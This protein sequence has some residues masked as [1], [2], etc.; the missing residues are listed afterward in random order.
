MKY[1]NQRAGLLLR[2][3]VA[4]IAASF[5]LYSGYQL[6]TYFRENDASR[7][8]TE[9]LVDKAVTVTVTEPAQTRPSQPPQE[10]TDQVAEPEIPLRVDFAA[11]K[12]ENPDIVG[13]IYC[14]GT[15]IH[16]P[17]LQ[18]RDNQ[19]YVYR[20]ADGSYN[21]SGSIF[22][23]YR[24]SW[25]MSDPNL[26][27]Y[28]HNMKNGSMFA[29]L[30]DYREQSYY[31]EHPRLWLLTEKQAYRV[32][33][34]AGTVTSADGQAFSLKEDREQLQAYLENC[35]A[36]STFRSGY[37]LSCVEQALTLSTCSYDFEDARYVV[38][39]HLV[40]VAYK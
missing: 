37:D 6:F 33:L 5:F 2:A 39:G 40:P 10:S 23:D 32:E 19:Y 31:E 13:W 36:H 22:L 18:G 17:V 34:I 16:Y 11:L 7:R 4:L 20:L 38:V 28:G 29:S 27:L 9:A 26:V 35:V 15:P 3:G 30:L 25:D 14:E 24:N 21:S 1:K 8:S 12:Q